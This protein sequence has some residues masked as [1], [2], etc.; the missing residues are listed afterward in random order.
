MWQFSA[1]YQAN[2]NTTIPRINPYSQITLNHI[3]HE[4]SLPVVH[5]DKYQAILGRL[6]EHAWPPSHADHRLTAVGK[7]V[8]EQ[9][10]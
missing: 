4:S 9:L 2:L 3:K 5:K 6:P 1:K 7:T 10:H 8:F